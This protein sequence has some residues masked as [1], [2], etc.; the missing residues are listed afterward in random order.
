[1]ID[2]GRP[3]EEDVEMSDAQEDGGKNAISGIS[4]CPFAH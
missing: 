2:Q 3:T 1:M 4:I